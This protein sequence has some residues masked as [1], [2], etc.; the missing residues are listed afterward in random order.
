[1]FSNNPG[2]YDGYNERFGGLPALRQAIQAYRKAGTLVTLY[3]DPLRVDDNS[4][5]GRQWGQ[6][7]G[8][9]QP[10]GRYRRDY[11]AW[12]MC[13]DVAGYRRF[14][15]ETV[16]RVLRET[17]ADGVR[18]DEYGHCGS[19]CSSTVHQHTF[20]EPGITEW[21]RAIAETTRLVRQAMDEVAPGSVLT[22]EHPGY[23]FLLPWIEGCITYDLS[24]QATPLRPLECNLQRFYF[25]ECKAYELVFGEDQDPGHRKRFWNGV[26]S[27]GSYYPAKMDR[28]LR[29]YREIFASRDCTPLVPT[30]APRVYANRFRAGDRTIYTLYNATGHT[31]AGPVLR[32]ELKPGEHV[33]DL[34]GNREAE[35]R[36]EGGKT[37]VRM[38][39]H[40]D[41]VACLLCGPGRPFQQPSS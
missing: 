34:F 11:D 12:R 9:V 23:D 22:T 7:W 13:H 1:M 18:L 4:K 35:C 17:R 28:L 38:F 15:A 6:L 27:F 21:P 2:D 8:V 20:A 10:D 26:A 19:A 36:V 3:T 32:L 14:V 37:T 41:Q 31:V 25:P 24:V 33:Y 30:L 5:C 39:L 40:R 29:Q 16:S